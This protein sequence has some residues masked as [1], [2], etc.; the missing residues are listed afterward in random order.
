M[1]L[2]VASARRRWT[3]SASP[4]ALTEHRY[5]WPLRNLS[6]VHRRGGGGLLFAP[7]RSSS[8]KYKKNLPP[9]EPPAFFIALLRHPRTM[10]RSRNA[11]QPRKVARRENPKN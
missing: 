5:G 10:A 6:P 2:R 1:C 4:H 3:R 8:Q 9:K 11:T 7:F